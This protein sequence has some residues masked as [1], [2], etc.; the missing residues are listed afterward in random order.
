MNCQTFEGLIDELAAGHLME[1]TQRVCADAHAAACARCAA[2]LA[3]ER[4]LTAGLR[5]LAAD[6]HVASAPPPRVETALLAA[7][8]AQRSAALTQRDA[9]NG[10]RPASLPATLRSPA[11]A[12][13]AHRSRILGAAAAT[14]AAAVL[15]SFGVAGMR[16]WRA[17]QDTAAASPQGTTQAG[18]ASSS[19]PLSAAPAPIGIHPSQS[20]IDIGSHIVEVDALAGDEKRTVPRA[21]LN[22][23]TARTRYRPAVFS[24][25]DVSRATPPLNA[26][27]D[28]EE[29]AT[30]FIPL[31]HDNSLTSEDSGQVMR[32][33]LPRS[34]LVSFGLPMNVERA[35]GR[36]K[37]DVLVGEDGVARAIRFVR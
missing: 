15:L 21:A 5:S 31:T 23:P 26:A 24:H 18:A 11:A 37:A 25:S 13:W 29:I 6:G 17:P 8:R 4:T 34:A 2:R 16:L 9:A 12:R 33:E 27:A 32:V 14:A 36:V 20:A 19:A 1:A 28:D 7:F 3:D 22:R 10:A 35:G 30:D